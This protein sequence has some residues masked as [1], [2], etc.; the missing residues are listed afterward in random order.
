MLMGYN[1]TNLKLKL[2]NLSNHNNTRK[3][4]N[5]NNEILRKTRTHQTSEHKENQL[6]KI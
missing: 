5:D 3:K 4:N 1:N 2:I 6:I